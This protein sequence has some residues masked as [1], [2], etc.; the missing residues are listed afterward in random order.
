MNISTLTSLDWRAL[1]NYMSLRAFEDLN[2]FLEALPQNSSKTILIAAGCIWGVAAV[3]CLYTTVKI[4][5]ISKISMQL[6]EAKALQPAVPQIKDTPVDPATIVAFVDQI[7][8]IYKGLEIKANAS[9]I[10]ITAK[11]TTQ[12]GEFREAVGHIQN[13]GAGWRVN[14]DRLCVGKECKQYPLAASVKITKVD[15]VAATSQ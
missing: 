3:V 12:F 4:Q 14:L 8:E 15:V 7:K 2:T 9:N 1:R 5:E 13:G 10:V 6:A 11:S